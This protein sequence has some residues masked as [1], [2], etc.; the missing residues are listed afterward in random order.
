MPRKNSGTLLN[1]KE[2]VKNLKSLVS[3]IELTNKVDHTIN[4][5][6]PVKMIIVFEPRKDADP[7]QFIERVEIKNTGVMK[8]V[9]GYLRKQIELYNNHFAKISLP[10]RDK[11]K[12]VK[13]IPNN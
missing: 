5:G 1:H 12:I 7:A 13:T 2:T 3:G 4:H 8:G 10:R 6:T 9:L 11:V